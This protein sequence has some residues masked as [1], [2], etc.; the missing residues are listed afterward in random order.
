[1]LRFTG[2][3]LTSSPQRPSAFAVLAENLSIVALELPS[4]DSE[5]IS[6]VQRFSPSLV[7]IDAPVGLPAGL[8]C[9]EESCSCHPVAKAKGRLCERELAKLGIPSYFTTK[10]SIIKN[11]V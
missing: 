5:I 2:I 1:M 7:A 9:L 11:M 3:D 6:A 4:T 8:C 10:R